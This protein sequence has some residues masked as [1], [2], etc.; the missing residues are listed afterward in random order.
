MG[1]HQFGRTKG[2]SHMSLGIANL[3]ERESE[4]LIH[5][6]FVCPFPR[7]EPR[8][9]VQHNIPSE[10]SKEEKKLGAN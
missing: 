4:A 8:D 1:D 10:Y 3:K 2:S 9:E 5:M 6:G 7:K